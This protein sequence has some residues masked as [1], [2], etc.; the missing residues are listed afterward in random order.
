MRGSTIAGIGHYVPE[1]VLT[2][3]ELERLIDTTDE[4][5]VT[6]TGIRERRVAADD[7]ASS[8]LGLE[9]AREAMADAGVRAEDLDLII[10]GTATPDNRF[11]A[12][13]GGPAARPR[14]ELAWS[15]AAT[16]RSRMPVRVTIHSSVV[17]MSRSS[18]ALVST[19]SG[20]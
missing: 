16:R 4:W 10:V 8:D 17:S 13:A 5:I 3:A 7:Q 6:R 19:R 20:T 12:T 9:A 11:P 1:R 15:A 18:S 2:N 14:W